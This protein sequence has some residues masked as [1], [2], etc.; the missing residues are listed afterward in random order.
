MKILLVTTNQFG[1]LVD[2]HRYYS[3]LKKKGH[4]VKYL[5]SD[6]K[7]ERIEGNNPD[8]IYVPGVKGKVN[9]HFTF[10][11]AIVE[12]DKQYNFDRIMIH[13]FP[14]VSLLSFFIKRQKIFLD[15]RTL[16]IHKKK[17]KRSFFDFLIKF[18]SLVYV[19]TSS[20]TGSAFFAS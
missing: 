3:Y 10:M 2:Y 16:S 19:N 12:A 8:I 15:I 14:L 13:V 17:Y 9:K 18:A 5:C 11:K 6:Y 4:D 20:I 7:K 1:Y